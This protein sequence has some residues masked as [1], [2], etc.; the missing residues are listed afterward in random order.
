MKYHYLFAIL[1]LIGLLGC[2]YN[3]ATSPEDSHSISDSNNV[4]IE[5]I[6][7]SVLPSAS[8]DSSVETQAPAWS[9]LRWVDMDG[10]TVRE[11]S[12]DSVLYV[13]GAHYDGEDQILIQSLDQSVY[14]LDPETGD[15]AEPAFPGWEAGQDDEPG[16]FEERRR[17]Y[18]FPESE[19]YY[20]A[21]GRET[22][23]RMNKT[24]GATKLIYRS[25]RPIYGI[26]ASLKGDY[27]AI[28]VDADL[29]YGPAADLIVLDEKGS[30][31]SEFKKASY[32][33]HSEGS[34]FVSIYPIKW[35][36][37]ETIAVRWL[38]SDF[39]GLVMYHMKQGL[40]RKEAELQMTEDDFSI[41][42][43]ATG[44]ERDQ[45]WV[46]RVMPKPDQPERYVAISVSG[47]GT[48][49]LD[50]EKKEAIF[51]GGG[52]LVGWTSKEEVLTWHSNNN[53]DNIYVE[54]IGIK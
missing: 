16:D 24:D 30:V 54:F 47:D 35:I 17:F 12:F 29:T 25:D 40:L 7:P 34:D 18:S 44:N 41:L 36:D 37:N 8:S 20:V 19:F 23:Y 46:Y 11:Q 51:T 42:K 31:V 2:S 15:I 26:A 33:S 48:F 43:S 45:S 10:R 50:R 6:K 32:I 52:A 1:I 39:E 5:E 49:I 38:G 22:I 21:A 53:D 4:V 14:S 9:G 13:I 27:I 28:L 3:G